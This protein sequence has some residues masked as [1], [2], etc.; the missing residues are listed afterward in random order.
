MDLEDT[1]RAF[2]V[3][4]A[5]GDK[6]GSPCTSMAWHGST[7]SPLWFGPRETYEVV[8][9]FN[10]LAAYLGTNA[11]FLPGARTRR[12]S[13]RTRTYSTSASARERILAG[14]LYG[15]IRA[16]P[17]EFPYLDNSPSV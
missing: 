3:G 5:I 13:G 9:P 8:Q 14:Y 6:I 7:R 17:R 12:K 2:R 4:S 16:V 10:R 15:G 11:A 1:I